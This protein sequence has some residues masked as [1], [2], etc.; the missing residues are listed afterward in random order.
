MAKVLISSL[1]VGQREKGYLTANYEINN[2]LYKEKKFIATVLCEQLKIDKLFLIGTKNSIWEVVFSEFGGDSDTELKIY[3]SKENNHLESY[4]PKIEKQIDERLNEHGSKCFII[5][6]GIN[7]AE[8]W[9]NFNK[10]L[11]ISEFIDEN[12]EVY[13]DITH[14]FRSLS[15][16]SFVM[17]EFVSNV[18]EY[19][20]NI[21]GVFYGMMEFSK[22]NEGTTPIIDLNIFFELLKWSK[23]IKNLKNYGNGYEL[24]NLFDNTEQC[25]EIK[26]SYKNFA[27]ALSLSDINKIQSSV[28]NLNIKIKVLED[29][30]NQIFK[31]VLQELKEFFKIFNAK[32]LSELQ[33]ELTSWYIKNKNYAM[34]YI[35]LVEASVSLICETNKQDPT[36]KN[37]RKDVKNALL[38]TFE[39]K[40]PKKKEIAQTFNIINKIRNNIAHKIKKEEELKMNCQDSINK[41]EKYVKILKGIKNFNF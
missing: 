2:I 8:L 40:D 6:Y 11:E 13:L 3:E 26:D 39:Y 32:S 35:T 27:Y 4:L 34:A 33:F 16:M 28:K 38:K 22:E 21:K 9:S 5:E 23:A 24:I 36:E 12:D 10:F 41:I 1:G 18:K 7:E 30:N 17:S 20:L 25:K 19:P 15:L 31:F 37:I 14:S 29:S